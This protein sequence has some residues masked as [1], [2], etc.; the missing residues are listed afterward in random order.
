M[1]KKN[2]SATIRT[3]NVDGHPAVCHVQLIR[4]QIF[5][6]RRVGWPPKKG[7]EFLDR[8]DVGLLR[9]LAHP[10][11]AH[12]IDHPLAQRGYSLLCHGNLLSVD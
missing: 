11:D 1:L 5:R 6:C 4:A 2:R 3:L 9:L 8:P 12:V 7:R 10:T